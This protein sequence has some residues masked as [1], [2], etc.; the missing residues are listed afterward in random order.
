LTTE[1]L[2]VRAVLLCDVGELKGKW[3]WS[4]HSPTP[5]GTLQADA[6]SLAADR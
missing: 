3:E 4:G 2:T 6:C 1:L 5:A